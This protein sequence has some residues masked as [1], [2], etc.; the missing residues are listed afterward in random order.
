MSTPPPEVIHAVRDLFARFPTMSPDAQTA[1]LADLAALAERERTQPGQGP[2][3]AALYDA[4]GAELR[5]LMTPPPSS[6]SR[7]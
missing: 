7:P 4:M 5:K 2:K 6:P 3:F 1:T